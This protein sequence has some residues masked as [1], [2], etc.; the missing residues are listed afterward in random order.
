MSTVSATAAAALYPEA[1]RVLKERRRFG[2][3][4]TRHFAVDV[5]H[6]QLD[7]AVRVGALTPAEAH[8]AAMLAVLAAETAPVIAEA[9]RQGVLRHLR[10]GRRVTRHRDERGEWTLTVSESRHGATSEARP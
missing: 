2:R 5:L 4:S 3:P 10:A 6:G 9:D 8:A 1:A 7:R